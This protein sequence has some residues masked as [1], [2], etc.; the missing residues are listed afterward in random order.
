MGRAQ[1]WQT[2]TGSPIVAN[3]IGIERF[4]PKSGSATKPVPGYDVQVSCRIAFLWSHMC[5]SRAKV[6]D[7]NGKQV[8]ANEKGNI[9]IKLPLPPGCFHTLWGNHERF[10]AGYL[11]RYPGRSL[12]RLVPDLIVC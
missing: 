10:V 8:A 12:A 9:V 7:D 11:K 2:E 3:P 1:W 4:T 6:L 5:C